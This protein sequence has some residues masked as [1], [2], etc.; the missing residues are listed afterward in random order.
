MLFFT[1]LDKCQI[2]ERRL[3]CTGL[4]LQRRANQTVGHCF[5]MWDVRWGI[6]CCAVPQKVGQLVILLTCSC[7]IK[8]K[9]CILLEGAI[10]YSCNYY[11]LVCFVKFVKWK[12]AYQSP[13]WSKVLFSLSDNPKPKAFCYNVYIK[14][15][16]DQN[17]LKFSH[18]SNACQRNRHCTQLYKW[19]IQRQNVLLQWQNWSM[20]SLFFHNVHCQ[21]WYVLGHKCLALLP[22]QP[23]A[24]LHTIR[25][26]TVFF[27][28]L[29]K[30]CTGTFFF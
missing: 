20:D 8:I 15:Q 6:K 12:N 27:F 24:A 14:L 1:V 4:F 17:I 25:P 7:F 28:F 16:Y 18:S 3:S 23:K 2:L 5:N 11:F 26:L 19:T 9:M 10:R 22:W 30:C 29:F 13:G 21:L